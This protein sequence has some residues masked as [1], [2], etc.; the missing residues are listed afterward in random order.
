[1]LAPA[2]AAQLLQRAPAPLLWWSCRHPHP[3]APLRALL[4]HA[5]ATRE[6]FVQQLYREPWPEAEDTP[7][8]AAQTALRLSLGLR[9]AAAYASDVAAAAVG[10]SVE[11]AV[12]SCYVAMLVRW[13]TVTE[14]RRRR[15]RGEGGEEAGGEGGAEDEGRAGALVRSLRQSEYYARERGG[16]R[17]GG[18]GARGKGGDGGGVGI[19]GSVGIGALSAL[20]DDSDD[21]GRPD[22]NKHA[23]PG[24]VTVSV[25]VSVAGEGEGDDDGDDAC[26][27]PAEPPS[28]ADIAAALRGDAALCEA[29]LGAREEGTEAEGV[30]GGG[31]MGKRS[32]V[33]GAAMRRPVYDFAPSPDNATSASASGCGDTRVGSVLR[34]LAWLI[35]ACAGVNT[36][37]RPVLGG[38]AD[39]GDVGALQTPR[40]EQRTATDS[41]KPLMPAEAARLF[42]THLPALRCPVMEAPEGVTVLTRNSKKTYD[43]RVT[44][45]PSPG[46]LSIP[47]LSKSLSTKSSGT[48]PGLA[49]PIAGLTS[50][51]HSAFIDGGNTQDK[52]GG[53]GEVQARLL[54]DGVL[55][56]AGWRGKERRAAVK[57]LGEIASSDTE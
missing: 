19:G 6:A 46:G 27:W 22:S 16:G 56:A 18:V 11:E 28:A 2:I 53:V 49:S 57:I 54:L 1:M 40:L 35:E 29:A 21:K 33:D 4:R 50:P 34:L 13:P 7:H 24:G 36:T 37:E 8:G 38:G 31:E 45:L 48:S 43:S 51:I 9:G 15:R 25:S 55:T 5:L 12:G 47:L 42:V 3:R 30:A 32:A 41:A 44:S 52:L 39:A 17:K 10:R 23:I 20:E 26:A 14:Q